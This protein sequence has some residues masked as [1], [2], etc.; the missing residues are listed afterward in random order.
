MTNSSVYVELSYLKD[1]EFLRYIAL[2]NL[3][4]PV[5]AI[6]TTSPLVSLLVPFK[7]LL[8]WFK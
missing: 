8:N 3:Y 1:L 6:L 5:F 4:D 2:V 7:N